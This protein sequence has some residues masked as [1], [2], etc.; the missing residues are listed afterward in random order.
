MSSD[1]QSKEEQSRDLPTEQDVEPAN[2]DQKKQRLEPKSLAEASTTVVDETSDGLDTAAASHIEEV[3]AASDSHSSSKPGEASTPEQ[4]DQLA[5]AGSGEAPSISATITSQ[6]QSIHDAARQA[7]IL[8]DSEELKSKLKRPTDKA[9]QAAASVMQNLEAAQE[10][11]FDAWLDELDAKLAA[12]SA[13]L[14]KA[15][16]EKEALHRVEAEI[17][18]AQQMAAERVAKERLEH[19]VAQEKTEPSEK[20]ESKSHKSRPVGEH[21]ERRKLPR[22]TRET[23]GPKK[24]LPSAP[25][26]VPAA[27]KKHPADKSGS[28]E[29]R[30]QAQKSQTTRDERDNLKKET[31]QEKIQSPSTESSSESPAGNTAGDTEQKPAQRIN[32]ATH[33]PPQ[34]TKHEP[35]A[36]TR[37][38]N[39]S[40]TDSLQEAANTPP[41]V[42]TCVPVSTTGAPTYDPEIADEYVKLRRLALDDRFWSMTK[43]MASFA[44]EKARNKWLPDKK[45]PASVR[46][47]AL[48]IRFREALVELGPTFIKL[49]QFL[50]VRR[51]LLEAEVA[52]ELATLQDKVPPFSADQAIKTIAQE[53]GQEPDK[54]F[55]E[56]DNTP[57]ASAS[58]GQVHRAR[59]HDGREVVVK[60][61]RPDL[62]SKFYQDLGYMRA[63]IRWGRRLKPDGDW[64]GWLALSDEFGRSLFSEIDYLQEGK[65][66][67]RMRINLRDSGFIR[68]PRVIWKYT[69]RHVLAFE[70]C[71]GIK[72][73]RI[74]ELKERGFDLIEIGNQL[75]Y[76]YL[77]QV[78]I[79]GYFHADPHAGNLAIDDEGRIIMYDFGMVGEISEA[80]RLAIAG[81][82]TSVIDKQ[83]ED[84]AQYLVEL[85][86][87]KAEANKAPVVRTLTPF[88]DYYS[89]RS[90]KDLD[91]SHL[92]RDIDQIALERA[93]KLPANLAYLLR[94]GSSVEGIARTLQPEFSFVEAAKPFIQRWL[95]SRPSAFGALLKI[96]LKYS[97]EA[98]RTS[99]ERLTS[100][101]GLFGFG[102]RK[103]KS[104]QE[105]P[106]AQPTRST[107]QEAANK[108]ISARPSSSEKTPPRV[109][110]LPAQPTAT[111]VTPLSL[112]DAEPE[113]VPATTIDSATQALERDCQNQQRQ[114]YLLETRLGKSVRLQ[115][116]VGWSAAGALV[117]SSLFLIASFLADYRSYAHLFLIGNGVMGAIILWH[118]VEAALLGNEI[119]GKR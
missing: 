108:G 57:I 71:P 13:L 66:A 34:A 5:T 27:E 119:Q 7:A 87:L 56:F 96:F 94:A 47:R 70:Y 104:G 39:S 17:A 63:L 111:S 80:Q 86:V 73:D 33:S 76:A 81:C 42:P 4:A 15:A 98:Y 107:A 109:T 116:I 84:V 16:E 38:K 41:T 22:D 85:G 21:K 23:S 2:T 112:P 6:A 95:L 78:L 36:V 77:E 103:E 72:I 25:D 52:D 31:N 18:A 62:A 67:D 58:I 54:L 10:K 24:L 106:R 49:G 46:K 65:N 55:L 88:I 45:V 30:N 32:K 29:E 82:V 89:G 68:I 1:S 14:D 92:E 28:R 40:V 53:L 90:V 37:R 61:Q 60:V 75:V 117:F 101:S 74:S 83:G 93:L 59:L 48:A 12:A 110:S 44:K 100:G 115:M 9:I 50:S 19:L 102:K 97:A 91:F 51:D 8:A 69:G 35:Q 105:I 79:H 113:D 43:L 20:R 3:P 118:L 64:D 11:D 114:I 26:S 99:A